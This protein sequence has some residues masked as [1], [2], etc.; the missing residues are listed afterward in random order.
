MCQIYPGLTCL[1]IFEL[2]SVGTPVLT[3]LVA[4]PL[5]LPN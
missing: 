5:L 4:S 1:F 2:S 3:A